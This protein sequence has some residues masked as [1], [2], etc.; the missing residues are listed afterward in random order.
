[1]DLTWS[2][3]T[4]MIWWLKIIRQHC[5]YFGLFSS[6]L[7]DYL[8]EQIALVKCGRRRAGRWSGCEQMLYFCS[9]IQSKSHAQVRQ[10]FLS[11]IW[12]PVF[13]LFKVH[14]SWTF[15][16]TLKVLMQL[17]LLLWSLKSFLE[18]KEIWNRKRIKKWSPKCL[19]NFGQEHTLS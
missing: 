8:Q 2:S 10:P 17:Y 14:H 7:Q 18:T 6:F 9:N 4:G 11:L 19:K 13:S 16:L 12:G 15:I 5:W 1:M 3:R